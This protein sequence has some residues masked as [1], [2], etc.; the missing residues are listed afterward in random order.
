MKRYTV[1]EYEEAISQKSDAEV[2]ARA[3]KIRKE[4]VSLLEYLGWYSP[5]KVAELREEIRRLRTGEK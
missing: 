3:V 1:E 2:S 5:S 4:I